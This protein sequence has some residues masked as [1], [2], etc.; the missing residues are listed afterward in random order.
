MPGFTKQDV[1]VN[2]EAAGHLN[3]QGKTTRRGKEI[4]FGQ[5]YHIPDKADP[6]TADASL[7]NGIFR[8]IFKKKSKH[9]PKEIKV[10]KTKK[11][12]SPHKM[13]SEKKKRKKK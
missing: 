12:S 4:K 2:I 11:K 1:K 5:T 3:L 6:A 13:V 10:G 7:K 9:K 8:L